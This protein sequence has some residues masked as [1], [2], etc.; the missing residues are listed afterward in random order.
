MEFI[1]SVRKKK[2]YENMFK[3]MSCS[4]KLVRFSFF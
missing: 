2:E 4:I 1:S 3:V